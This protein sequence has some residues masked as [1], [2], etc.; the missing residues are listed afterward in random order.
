MIL[1]TLK[2]EI[3]LIIFV[4]TT[5]LALAGEIILGVPTVQGGS[6][7]TMGNLPAP[8]PAPNNDTGV[9]GTD[10]N[11]SPNIIA[12]SKV[13]RTL[14]PIRIDYVVANSGGTTEYLFSDT[15]FNLTGQDWTDYHITLEFAFTVTGPVGDPIEILLPAGSPLD[16]DTPTKDPTPTALRFGMPVFAGLT[17]ESNAISWF[18]GTLPAG[19]SANFTFSI[20]VPDFV[21]G[22]PPTANGY[23]FVLLQQPTVPEPSTLL[24]FASGL[25]T[26]IALMKRALQTR[27]VVLLQSKNPVRGRST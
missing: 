21:E 11:P 4:C 6:T 5:S 18:M 9:V 22:F 13:F 3:L 23:S 14:D 17:H 16:F 24:L 2:V 20:D 12:L 25:T 7:V 10:P 8:L 15:V 1:A 27:H 19:A 26:G